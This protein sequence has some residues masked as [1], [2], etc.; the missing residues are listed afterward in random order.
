MDKKTTL[1]KLL[2]GLRDLDMQTFKMITI[3]QATERFFSILLSDSSLLF[4]FL[5]LNLD[6][7]CQTWHDKIGD[8]VVVINRSLEKSKS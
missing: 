8:T 6:R 1:V 2:L 5:C 7:R 3:K 4:G